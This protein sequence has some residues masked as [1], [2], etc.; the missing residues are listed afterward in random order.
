MPYPKSIPSGPTSVYL[1]YDVNGVLLYVGITS[2]AISRQR[3]HNAD[4]D[5]WPFVSI[6][7]VEHYP[8]RA[9]AESRKRGLI[10]RYHP[11]FNTQ[12]NPGHERARQAYFDLEGGD[13]A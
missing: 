11:P 2:R 6:Q 4:K 9:H 7:S 8:S 3:E 10:R 12:H 5:W 1:Y 13:N